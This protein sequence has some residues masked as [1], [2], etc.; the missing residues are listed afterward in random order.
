MAEQAVPAD[1]SE[2]AL[3]RYLAPYRERPFS[4]RAD[5]CVHF[6]AGWAA[7]SR[8]IEAR[9]LASLRHQLALKHQ[10]HGV[11]GAVSAVLGSGPRRVS[12]LDTGDLAAVPVGQRLRAGGP[13]LAM[14][15]VNAAHVALRAETGLMLAPL[16]FALM[17]WRLR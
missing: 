10:H 2:A 14:G 5:N 7:R 8:A 13:R 6:V 4:W 3:E 9:A 16:S 17:G 1:L 12:E 11:V 15:I